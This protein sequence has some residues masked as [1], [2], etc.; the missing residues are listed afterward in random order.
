MA[1]ASEA[2]GGQLNPPIVVATDGSAV[3][4]LAVAWAAVDA[5]LH[6]SPLEIVTSVAVPGGW[7][8]GAMLTDTDTDWLRLEG[9][10]VVAE[11]TRVARTAAVGDALTISSDITFDTAIPHLIERSRHARLVV[12]GSRGRG[13]VRRGLL[14]SVSTAL[15][16]HAHCPIAVV[17][18]TAAIDPVA[19]EKPVLVGVDGTPNSVPALELAFEEASRRKVGLDALH[20]WSDTNR[21]GL[22]LPEWDAVRERETELL[23]ER[24][25]GF[26]ERYP[27]VQVRRVLVRDRP[28]QSLLDASE[29]AQLLVVGSHGRGGFGG[30]LLGSTSNAL[31]HSV[32]CPMI[33]VPTR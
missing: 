28:I 13:A 10:R 11:A 9:E 1:Q 24:L 14:G 16:R 19:A 32:E 17:H 27:D 30:M 5:G 29:N 21:A 15:T 20:A 8:P 4:Y 7:G 18:S 6:G 26:G 31:L 22:P 33:V 25:A 3:S 12:V 2:R 23:G